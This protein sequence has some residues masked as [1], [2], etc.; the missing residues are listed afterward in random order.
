MRSPSVIALVEFWSKLESYR[1]KPWR[2]IAAIGPLTLIRFALGALTLDA[3]LERLS[4]IVNV[5][6]AAADLPFAEA[7]I[8]VDKPA[9]LELANEILSRRT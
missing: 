8:D 3:A 9:D 5:R 2:M 7:A 6:I 1:K 4:G